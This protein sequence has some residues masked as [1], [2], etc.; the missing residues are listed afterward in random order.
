MTSV[1]RLLIINS[2]VFLIAL[3]PAQA[4]NI[5]KWV[6]ENGMTHYGRTVPP[7]YRDRAH[8]ELNDRGIELRRHDRAKTPE[9]IEKDKALAALRAEQQK[10]K[11]EQEA[12]DRILLSLYRNEDDLVMA[13]DGKMAQLDSQIK[14]NH[15]EI[16]RLK[17]RL[18]DFQT[19]AAAAERGGRTLTAKQQANLESTQRSI[20][21]SYAMILGKEDEKRATLE[22][23]DYDLARFRKLRQGGARAANAD[24]FA[25]SDIPDLVDTAVRCESDKECSQL[26]GVAQ[27]Y[28]RENAT[29]PIDLAAD[30]I[31]VTAPPRETRDISITVSR[32]AD[33]RSGGERIFMD[34]QC[35]GFTEGKEFCRGPEVEAIRD[36]FRAALDAE[37]ASHRIANPISPQEPE[38]AQPPPQAAGQ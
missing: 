29:T 18:S 32:L 10:L 25:K 24:I 38:V 33:K 3:A 4:G 19:A 1:F 6:D 26:W 9:E 34:V 14:L 12:R 16:R 2:I 36:K 21:R 20:E 30:R 37:Q 27:Q 11:E 15:K 17:N 8:S 35:V 23:Y 13:R 31:L 7:Q 5:K 28:A 22:R